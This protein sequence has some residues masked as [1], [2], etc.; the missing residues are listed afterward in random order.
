[1]MSNGLQRLQKSIDLGKNCP[2]MI[3]PFD[4]MLKSLDG[5]LEQFSPSPRQTG[6]KPSF[7]LFSASITG[8]LDKVKE[9]IDADPKSVNVTNSQ[10][11]TPLMYIMAN[12]CS[13]VATELMKRGA[14]YERL[15][16]EGMSALGLAGSYG[17]RGTIKNF[18]SALK[19]AKGPVEVTKAV[20]QVDAHGKTALH[21]AAENRQWESCNVL[22]ANGADP[23]IQDLEGNTALMMAVKAGHS[24]TIR[25]VLQ[26]GGDK[27][28]ANLKGELP[29]DVVE[30]KL[31]YIFEE[32]KPEKTGEDTE[33]EEESDGEEDGA[34]SV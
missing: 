28:I 24:M 4:E 33:S 26:K 5:K 2:N 10:G 27:D 13:F 31:K 16:F 34:K 29:M 6:E 8:H 11:W 17:H 12:G 9:M 3:N 30:P 20:N 23:N 7:T 1:M 21:Y 14:E 25:T 19:K 15:N 18:C 32:D 22:I